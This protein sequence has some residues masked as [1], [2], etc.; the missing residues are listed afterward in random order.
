MKNRNSNHR[1]T[2]QSYMSHSNNLP[3]TSLQMSSKSHQFSVKRY[4]EFL[5]LKSYQMNYFLKGNSENTGIKR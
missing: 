4:R 2:A 1:R 3:V 5:L